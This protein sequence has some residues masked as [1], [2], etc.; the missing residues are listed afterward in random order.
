[1]KHILNWSSLKVRRKV[2]NLKDKEKIKSG[3]IRKEKALMNHLTLKINILQINKGENIVTTT[4]MLMITNFQKRYLSTG[5]TVLT[6]MITMTTITSKVKIKVRVK[7]K[8]IRKVTIRKKEGR[9]MSHMVHMEVEIREIE[10]RR[11]KNG[12]EAIKYTT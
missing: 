10:I 11:T 3:K 8:I 9:A 1:M 2:R 4:M 12:K 7:R 6:T 5:K